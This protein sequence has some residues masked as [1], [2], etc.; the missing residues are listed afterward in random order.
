MKYLNISKEKDKEKDKVK[1]KATISKEHDIKYNQSK[2]LTG[3]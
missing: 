3:C 2:W 1:V